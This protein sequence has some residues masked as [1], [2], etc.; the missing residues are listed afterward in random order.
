MVGV[1][2]LARQVVVAEVVD[3]VAPVSAAICSRTGL[4]NTSEPKIAGIPSARI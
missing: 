3:V 1:A 2:R 4:G